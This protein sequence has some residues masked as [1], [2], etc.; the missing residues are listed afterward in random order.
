MTEITRAGELFGERLRALRNKRGVTQV[1]LA[2]RTGLPQS[3]VSEMERGL[4]LPN[5]ATLIRIAVALD[6]K[7]SALVSVLDRENPAKLLP[8]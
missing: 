8:K 5:L 2:E 6:C 3:H 7:I 4:T 1:A